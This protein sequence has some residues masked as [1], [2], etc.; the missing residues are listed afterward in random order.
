METNITKLLYFFCIYKIPGMVNNNISFLLQAALSFPRA[1][2]EETN[3][4]EGSNG[5]V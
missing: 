5:E 3:K 4:L 1:S 2:S